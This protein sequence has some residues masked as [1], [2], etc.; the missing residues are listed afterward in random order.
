MNFRLEHCFSSLCLNLRLL[1]KPALRSLV[2][3]DSIA[4]RPVLKAEDVTIEAPN[5][6]MACDCI[7]RINGCSLA[8][9]CM[10]KYQTGIVDK[11]ITSSFVILITRISTSSS[12]VCFSFKN[13]MVEVEF[14]GVMIRSSVTMNFVPLF[15]NPLVSAVLLPSVFGSIEVTGTSLSQSYTS[16]LPEFSDKRY[17]LK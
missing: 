13:P 11:H 17:S 5:N 9:I 10:F 12:R 14:E 2:E 7:Y 4:S 1:K 8:R 6:L 3:A 15:T 16:R